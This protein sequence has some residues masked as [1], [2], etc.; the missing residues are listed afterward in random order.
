VSATSPRHATDHEFGSLRFARIGTGLVVVG[1]VV[2][3][4]G[5]VTSTGDDRLT[6]SDISGAAALGGIAIAVVG[7]LAIVF[8][9]PLGRLYAPAGHVT[10]QR[11]VIQVGIPAAA[12]IVV[13]AIAATIAN[14]NR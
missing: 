4:I 1:A 10:W 7:V 2:A 6:L 5:F 13:L 14:A 9:R 11:R 12:F 3:A 8:A